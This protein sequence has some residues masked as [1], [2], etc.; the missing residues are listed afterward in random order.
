MSNLRYR[1]EIIQ[2]KTHSDGNDRNFILQSNYYPL[3]ILCD[4][5]FCSE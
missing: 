2:F 1:I 3:I 5:N 4:D